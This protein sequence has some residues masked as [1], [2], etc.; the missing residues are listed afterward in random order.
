MKHSVSTHNISKQE[1][2]TPY[3]ILPNPLP[4]FHIFK[5]TPEKKEHDYSQ[6]KSDQTLL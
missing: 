4:V 5:T 6:P 3:D 2:K 1:T